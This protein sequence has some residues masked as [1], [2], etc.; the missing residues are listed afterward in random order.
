MPKTLLALRAMR[1]ADT[2]EAAIPKMATKTASERKITLQSQ[3]QLVTAAPASANTMI[4]TRVI[5]QDLT[6]DLP[7][8]CSTCLPAIPL[9]GRP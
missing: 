2:M 8:V 6:A 5:P 9:L 1:Y 4:R 3:I 7:L